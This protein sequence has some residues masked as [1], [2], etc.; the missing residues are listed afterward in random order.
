MFIFKQY[1][2]KKTKLNKVVPIVPLSM[3]IYF[4]HIYLIYHCNKYVYLS[5]GFFDALLVAL[6]I[7]IISYIITKIF[8]SIKGL[9]YCT[10]GISYTEAC[11]T[12]N[13]VYTYKYHQ[14]IHQMRKLLKNNSNQKS[15][16]E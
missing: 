8:A 13:F 11:K 14:S 4:I 5:T 7:F 10:L 9:S 16:Q 1:A 15:K 6:I 12:C 2:H 3:G